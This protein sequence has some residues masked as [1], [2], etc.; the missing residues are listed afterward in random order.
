HRRESWCC[1]RAPSILLQRATA[2]PAARSIRLPRVSAPPSR[3]L[4]DELR[5]AVRNRGTS[6]LLYL[7]AELPWRVSRFPSPV[8]LLGRPIV[9]V[10]DPG[11]E[12]SHSRD[13]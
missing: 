8:L 1:S 6:S 13:S 10:K 12:L 3:S 5:R 4:S 9:L 2:V 7:D 11:E